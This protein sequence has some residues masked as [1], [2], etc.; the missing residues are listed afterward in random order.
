MIKILSQKQ[1][2]FIYRPFSH[3]LDV[4]EGTPRS[5][6]THASTRRFA[7]HLRGSD[8]INH[9][10]VGYN[11]EQAYRLI[12]EG[13]GHG[14]IHYFKGSKIKHDDSGDYLQV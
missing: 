4:A 8:D 5:G 7:L 3:C 11:Q 9:L 2:D 13:D 14:L 10:I 6:K 12:I 1:I